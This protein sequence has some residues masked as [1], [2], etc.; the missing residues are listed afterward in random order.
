MKRCDSMG[1]RRQSTQ[2]IGIG[3]KIQEVIT[4]RKLFNPRFFVIHNDVL[5]YNEHTNPTK[6][7]DA[8]RIGIPEVKL[9]ETVI[10]K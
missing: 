9:K 10:R 3:E 5:C 6:P 7:Y 2:V 1:Q 8:Q 4:V